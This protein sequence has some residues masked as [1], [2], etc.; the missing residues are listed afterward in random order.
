MNRR[1]FIKTAAVAAG[2]AP[3]VDS[4]YPPA[5]E[6]APATAVESA[7]VSVTTVAPLDTVFAAGSF[8]TLVNFN[9]GNKRYDG[10]YR[11]TS[12]APNRCTFNISQK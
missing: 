12:I 6:L 1:D 9:C 10:I 2:F 3:M 11:V 4:F 5:M 7:V 8:L